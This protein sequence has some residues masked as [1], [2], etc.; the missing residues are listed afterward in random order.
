MKTR[1]ESRHEERLPHSNNPNRKKHYEAPQF[2]ILGRD[3]AK[4]QLVATAIAGDRDAER[5]LALISE[6]VSKTDKN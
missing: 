5:M 6:V 2:T 4:A 1:E 3:Q